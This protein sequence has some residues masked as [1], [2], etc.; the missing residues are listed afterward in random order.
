MTDGLDLSKLLLDT[1]QSGAP[2]VQSN[3]KN[4]AGITPPSPGYLLLHPMPWNY[5]ESMEESSHTIFNLIPVSV[6]VSGVQEIVPF[7]NYQ[8]NPPSRLSVSQ[9]DLPDAVT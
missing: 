8:V 3:V 1:E 4:N 5:T 9:K 6:T 2:V 7:E